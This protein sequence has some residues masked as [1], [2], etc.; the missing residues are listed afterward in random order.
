MYRVVFYVFSLFV[1]Q[2]AI[3]KVHIFSDIL[4]FC[5]EFVGAGG[6]VGQ[7]DVGFGRGIIV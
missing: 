3:A 7:R 1:L 6:R 2:F 4:G 5:S